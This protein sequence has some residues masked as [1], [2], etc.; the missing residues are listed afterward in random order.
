M[1][2]AFV[3]IVTM[4]IF[5]ALNTYTIVKTAGAENMIVYPFLLRMLAFGTYL[6]KD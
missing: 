6:M 2:W 3:P 5:N 4:D 1:R